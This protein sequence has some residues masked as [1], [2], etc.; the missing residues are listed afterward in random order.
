MVE[1]H[2]D[3]HWESVMGTM[4]PRT[5]AF[6]PDSLSVKARQRCRYAWMQGSNRVLCKLAREAES[7]MEPE[8]DHP[9]SA[10]RCRTFPRTT[11]LTLGQ[12]IASDQWGLQWLELSYCWLSV[13]TGVKTTNIGLGGWDLNHQKH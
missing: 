2:K 11:T 13:D 3:A 1:V 8:P 7:L 10:P 6:S 5:W 9:C 4:L 12:V